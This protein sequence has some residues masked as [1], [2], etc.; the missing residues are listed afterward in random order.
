M[1]PEINRPLSLFVW[2]LFIFTTIIIALATYSNN[3]D[4]YGSII[5]G[6]D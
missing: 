4:D 5:H 3:L 1:V 2:A 6:S